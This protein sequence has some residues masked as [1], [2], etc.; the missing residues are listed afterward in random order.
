MGIG[1]VDRLHLI[2]GVHCNVRC[3]MCYQT[4]FSRD[5][6]MPAVIYQEHLRPLYPQIKTAKLQGGEPTIMRN[7]KEFCLLARD[8]PEMKIAIT[9]NG[10]NLN[11][12]WLDTMVNQGQYV[13]ISL[14]AAHQETYDK[15][16]KHGNF[17]KAVKNIERLVEANQGGGLAIALSQVIIPANAGDVLDFLKLGREL[18]VREINFGF[19]PLLTFR[20]LPPQDKLH[21]ML[22]DSFALLAE[23][24]I[25]SEGLDVFARRV[26]YAAGPEVLSQARPRCPLPFRNLVVDEKGDARVCCNTWVTVGNTYGQ[27]IEQIVGGKP[28][29]RF[30]EMIKQDNYRWCDPK[31][32]DNPHPHRLATLHKYATAARKDPKGFAGKVKAK[33]ATRGKM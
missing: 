8:Y 31:C 22:A 27:S 10:I 12:F 9:T 6:A 4:S 23:N 30:Q 14:N 11:D 24:N 26:G 28:V 3:V 16:V 17:P 19:D 13:N 21:Q 1:T 32:S 7:C 18:G 25:R 5:L 2:M 33:L 15:I 20:G 29:K